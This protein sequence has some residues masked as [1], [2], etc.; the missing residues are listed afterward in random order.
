MEFLL[1]T[2]QN[3][4][5]NEFQRIL[6]TSLTLYIKNVH[7]TTIYNSRKIHVHFR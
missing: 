6:R 4:E 5:E 7:V 1:K 2:T 3:G